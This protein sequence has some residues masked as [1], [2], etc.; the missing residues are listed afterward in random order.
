MATIDRPM[1]LTIVLTAFSFGGLS[2]PFFQ[3]VSAQPVPT[4]DTQTPLPTDLATVV[5]V[6]GQS[7]ILWG[8]IQPKVDG[9]IQAVLKQTKQELPPAELAKARVMLSHAA[10]SQS[11]QSKMLREAFLQDQIGTQASEKREEATG[12]MLSRAR[13]M[14]FENELKGLK[15]KYNT[16]DLS[17][18]D[19]KLRE[20]GSSLQARQ[21]EFTD[22]MLGHMFMRSKVPQDP[23]VTIAE[24]NARYRK[25]IEQYKQGARA[26]WEQLS[27]MFSNHP[28]KDAARKAIV[29]MGREAYFGGNLQAVAKAKSE[30][31]FASDGGLHDWTSQG[32]LASKRLDQEIFSIPLNKMSEIV[33]D[34]QGL[35][36]I[37]V[38]ERKA[39][40]VR[41][42]HELQDEIRE[43]IKKEKVRDAQT[44]ML[45]EMKKSIPV[46]SI[47]PDDVEGAKPIRPATVATR[48]PTGSTGR[49]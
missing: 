38:L 23:N 29:E 35:H 2:T 11:I 39:P 7:P 18:V 45:S 28:N 26:R 4:F 1:I 37:R 46:W 20:S 34:D 5:A 25:D 14:F 36:I 13:Q 44:K 43:T 12:I 17:V 15:K 47:F 49:F 30:E 19:S 24:I 9:R 40:G 48:P 27:V 10:L 31:P 3:T 32:S 42:L 22:M 41:P 6:V 8:D 21:R 16:E 33:E